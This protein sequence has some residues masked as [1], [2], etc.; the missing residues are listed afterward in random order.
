MG[1]LRYD[2]SLDVIT[3]KPQQTKQAVLKWCQERGLQQPSVRDVEESC[4]WSS[5]C[6]FSSYLENRNY[7]NL[8]NADTQKAFAS[9]LSLLRQFDRNVRV[10]TDWQSLERYMRIEAQA[11]KFANKTTQ[12]KA[13][14]KAEE[15]KL[16]RRSS[17]YETANFDKDDDML[18]IGTRKEIQQ[19]L[20]AE[21]A[22]KVR[23]VPVL[24]A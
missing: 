22:K 10:K 23:R 16:D 6:V 11:D 19:H 7:L 15:E 21:P 24:Q 14:M 8:E 17:V 5:F 9:L 12:I 13:A 18:R 1:K 4:G 3:R 20:E 2:F